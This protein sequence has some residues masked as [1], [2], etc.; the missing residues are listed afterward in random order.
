MHGWICLYR[1]IVEC[2]LWNEKPFDRAR[3]WIDLLLMANHKDK[4][5]LFGNKVIEVKRGELITSQSKLSNRWGWSRRKIQD[6]LKLLERLRMV[7]TKSTAKYTSVT[8]INYS[9]YQNLGTSESTTDGTTKEQVTSIKK[10]GKEQ[11]TSTNNNVEQ[12]LTTTNNGNNEEQVEQI[13]SNTLSS[14]LD[15]SDIV[16]II[17]YLNDMAGTHYRPQTNATIGLIKARMNE[18]FTV[19]DFKTVIGKKCYEWKNDSQ[20]AKFLRP[21]TLF[22]NKFESY[23]NQQ[24][25]VKQSNKQKAMNDLQELYNELGAK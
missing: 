8:V 5:F 23:L 24:Q 14:K 7:S 19:E 9:K 15:H 1:S 10:A 6:Y 25:P 4:S 21:Q 20:Y 22:G 17:D 12:C 3:A 16:T 13:K 18:G 2:E 11:V